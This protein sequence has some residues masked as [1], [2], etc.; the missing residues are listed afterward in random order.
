MPSPRTP[1]KRRKKYTIH[2]KKHIDRT[3]SDAKV[4]PEIQRLL[5]IDLESAKDDTVAPSK[6][7]DLKACYGAPN[8]ELR[9]AVCR[10]ITQL[11]KW[12]ISDQKSY[13]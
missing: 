7:A 1:T 5:I 10:R 8:T 3:R 6:I 9:R 13:W 4:Q 2:R 11:R 12:K